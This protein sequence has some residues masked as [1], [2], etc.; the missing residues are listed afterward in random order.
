MARWISCG[1]VAMA[2]LSIVA[3]PCAAQRP[4]N[5]TDSNP[6]ISRSAN[7]PPRLL[8]G[9]IMQQLRSVTESVI[10]TPEERRAALS[11]GKQPVSSGPRTDN[12]VD[13]MPGRERN[14]ASEDTAANRRTW[15][16]QFLVPNAR[17]KGYEAAPKA[18]TQP[19]PRQRDFSSSNRGTQVPTGRT[20]NG[21]ASGPKVSPSSGVDE[22]KVG[23][24]RQLYVGRP[25]PGQEPDQPVVAIEP[26]PEVVSVFNR[27]SPTTPAPAPEASDDKV[28]LRFS[29]AA[30]SEA[31]EVHVTQVP[32]VPFVPRKPLPKRVKAGALAADSQAQAKADSSRSQATAATNSDNS[33]QEDTR[34]E[35]PSSRIAKS[36]PAATP[37]PTPALPPAVS[38]PRIPSLE[39]SGPSISAPPS[40]IA[41]KTPAPTSPAPASP[42]PA[43]VVTPQPEVRANSA[44]PALP[45]LALPEPTL[46]KPSS[47]AAV[48]AQP[49]APAAAAPALTSTPKPSASTNVQPSLTLPMP[50]PTTTASNSMQPVPSRPLPRKTEPTRP[51]AAQ[52][53]SAMANVTK[54][55]NEAQERMHMEIPHVVVQ[56][57]GPG[58]LAAGTP[59]SY[60][61][62][63]QNPDSIALQGL[64]LR[65]ETPTGVDVRPKS[66]SSGVNLEKQSGGGTLL[67][68]QVAQV[69]PG[70][71]TKMPLE[72]NASSAKNF[73]VAIEWTVLPQS[74]SE[75]LLVKHPDLQLALEGP[76]EVEHDVPNLYRLRVSNTG[77]ELARQV[78]VQVTSQT[79]Q[80]SEVEIGDL[81]VGQTELIEMDLTFAKAGQIQIGAVASAKGVPAR[82][83][84]IS[85]NV[86]QAVLEARL[87]T[88]AVAPFGTPLTA[89]VVVKNVGDAPARKVQVGLAIPAGTQ[90][91]NLPSGFSRDGD[92][93]LWE[94]DMIS[95]GQIW[96]MPIELSMTAPGD[97][98]LQLACVL[99]SGAVA[100]AQATTNIEAFADLTLFVNDPPAPAPIGTPVTYE[101]TITNRGGCEARD[102]K[103]VAQF[104]EGIEPQS[105]AGL[106]N[107]VVTGQVLFEPIPT[108][109]PGQTVKLQVVALASAPGTH[110]FRTEVRC[111]ESDVR[112]VEEEST[113][114]L[115]S[116]RRVGAA[117]SNQVQR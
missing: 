78:K 36:A 102:V 92:K 63:V 103:I 12:R 44:Q 95:V 46:A 71:T 35:Q 116:A 41:T 17:S 84:Q 23:P 6:E 25:T 2:I 85:V 51:D 113:R 45:Q 107:R 55:A 69:P 88:P 81:A 39:G 59:T 10:G 104:S 42:L 110:R 5:E 94:I 101:M 87:E 106:K 53:L 109:A 68:W 30:N 7:E 43:A 58:D 111:E 16:G 50:A 72:L 3:H 52:A 73:A 114:Y 115:E 37:S 77:N 40:P 18:R 66:G 1:W 47:V 99:A 29:D 76:A 15:A 65:M 112:L 14:E 11:S 32:V 67:T 19:D 98:R 27:Q 91:P 93:L 83:T 54:S 75:D 60:E 4:S 24:E 22:V 20:N 97:Q 8:R 82:N 74:D 38:I 9:G 64:I 49:S 26:E 100:S 31:A 61:L 79:N 57:L 33:I 34:A 48:V 108:I 80:A 56:L 86:R 105:A 117:I 28:N 89:A 90:L 70:T 96:T 13:E 21:E 62:V